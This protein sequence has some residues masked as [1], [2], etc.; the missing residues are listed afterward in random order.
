MT[1]V[2]LL[3]VG[4][5]GWL[6]SRV[7]KGLIPEHD[8]DQLSVS[9]EGPQGVSYYQMAKYTQQVSDILR[10][11]PNIEA[12]SASIGGNFNTGANTGRMW[13]QLKPRKQRAM[14]VT[15]IIE[16]LRPKM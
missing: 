1:A 16:K 11:D 10:Q 5:T 6:F 3:T 15:E 13:V 12:F 9:L 14:H 2:F 4:V 8:T 7:P